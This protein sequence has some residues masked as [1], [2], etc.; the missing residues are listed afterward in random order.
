VLTPD[1]F[2]RKMIVVSTVFN[3]NNNTGQTAIAQVYGLNSFDIDFRQ[4]NYKIIKEH[5]NFD[6]S[7]EY[8][9]SIVLSKKFLDCE[10]VQHE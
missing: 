6:K 3:N 8:H 9:N 2:L 5:T 10:V 1:T 4:L 7:Q